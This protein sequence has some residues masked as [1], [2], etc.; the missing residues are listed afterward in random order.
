[1]NA[2]TDLARDIQ[3]GFLNRLSLTSMRG[4]ALLGGQLGG[5]VVLGLVQA[6]FYVLVGLIVGVRFASGRRRR[7]G[8]APVRGA[9][10]VR[11]SA[12]SAPSWRSAPA[13]ARRC[14]GLFPVLFVFL[15]ISSMNTPRDLIAVDWFR[16]SRPSTPSRT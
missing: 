12:R 11:R 5:V 8:A 14:R 1:M 3:T 16:T 13:R 10:L 15:F 7:A 2:G 9:R 6:V 4:M